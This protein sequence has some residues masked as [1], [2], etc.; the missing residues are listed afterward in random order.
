MIFYQCLPLP[1]SGA[2]FLHLTFFL[3]KYIS[4]ISFYQKMG[5]VEEDAAKI[6]RFDYNRTFSFHFDVQG[7]SR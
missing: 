2:G 3:Q 5:R 1:L 7:C 6:A 4:Q